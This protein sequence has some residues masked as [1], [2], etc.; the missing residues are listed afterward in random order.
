MPRSL[1]VLGCLL[2]AA[3]VSAQ[4]TRISVS[5]AGVEANGPSS[6]PA[7]SADGRFVAFASAATNLVAGDTNGFWDIFLRDRDSDADG[8]LDEAGAVATTRLSVG[9][10]GVQGN[11]TSINPVITADGRFVAYI[12]TAN[13][14]AP[15][16]GGGTYQVYRLDRTNGATMLVSSTNTGDVANRESLA[17]S[18]TDDGEWV[19]FQSTATNLH[20]SAASATSH[21]FMKFVPQ[22][23]LLYVSDSNTTRDFVEP[24][25][26]AGG[27]RVLYRSI[28]RPPAPP[29]VRLE[30]HERAGQ[31]N[32]RV[33][34]GPNWTVARLSTS[35]GQVAGQ[36]MLGVRRLGIDLPTEAGI[37]VP[38][39]LGPPIAVSPSARYVLSGDGTVTNVDLR[40]A[41][42]LGFPVTGGAFGA[43]DRWLA[44]ASENA[45]L[46]G[47]DTNGV[48]DVFAVD[49]PDALDHDNDGI[50]DTWETVFQ[51]TDPAA[52]PDA[53]GATNAQEFAAGS[54]PNGLA[55]RF[56]AEG[57]TGTFFDTAIELANPDATQAATAVLTF[58]K[59]DGTRARHV[60]S[61]PS[62]QS[63][64][65]HVASAPGVE[66]ADVS[67]T[68]ESD[69]VL[70]VSRTMA[71]DRV[72]PYVAGRGYGMHIETAAPAPS[73]T[74]IFAEGST[75]LDFDLYYLLLNPQPTTTHATVRYLLPG[76]DVVT[77]TY[78]LPPG[79]R[80]TIHVNDVPG[81]GETDVSAE[82]TADAAVVAE[83][84]MYRSVPNRL[85]EVGH[86]ATGV[87]A[88]ATQW[89]LAEGATGS[90]FDL[91]VLVA[92]PGN[93]DAQVEA[94]Y[95]RPD[96]STVTRQ[97]VVRAH[98]RFS[99]YVDAIE[100]LQNT[101][102]AT[103]MTS[104]N[105]VPIVVERS[106]YWPGNFFGYYEGHSAVGSTSTAHRWVV[107]GAE[108]NAT[109]NT[110]TYV[111]IA[112]T[113]NRAGTARLTILYPHAVPAS[114]P[115]PIQVTLPPN[116]RTTVE[117][118][119]ALYVSQP[120]FGV[121]VESTGSSPVALVVESSTYRTAYQTQWLAGGNALATPLP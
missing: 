32:R 40:A 28:S 17:P 105:A 94:V 2:L 13:N 12:S 29:I 24:S 33:E 22:G 79:S 93:T 53:D 54:H 64:S 3:P 109:Q 67:T 81:L 30:M 119:S 50:D 9:P 27:W 62:L 6:V 34:D 82:V 89:F 74:W 97:Y 41:G 35:G 99:V 104:T 36:T 51:V 80:T 42:A 49:L 73:P 78:D 102:V 76:G 117:V 72:P 71:W 98:S 61:V 83:R 15:G 16:T 90:F 48:V 18:I 92:N 4:V 19:A 10:G 96:G 100:G 65:I 68:V 101:S 69:R 14:L 7:I 87:P 110:R 25:V 44:V 118:P 116:S 31:F 91:Y 52:D 66:A 95:A 108:S 38:L 58:D 45:T 39:T 63:R 85:F 5:T 8:V 84:A 103:T 47:G 112:N 114:D 1:V 21:V 111:Q 20:P 120:T 75:V 121:L 55:R 60:V 46:V 26:S 70:G 106:M 59:G 57:A 11:G 113:E 115:G 88:A 23:I 77:R 86:V 56:L 107:S 43:G 37:D